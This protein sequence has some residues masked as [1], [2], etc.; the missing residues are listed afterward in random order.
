MASMNLK[1]TSEHLDGRAHLIALEGEADLYTAPEL[2]RELQDVIDQGADSVIVDLTET[3]FIDST[4]LGVLIGGV[5][6]LRPKGGSVSLICTDPNIRK[7]FEITL[8]DRVFPIYETRSEAMQQLDR[9]S[10]PS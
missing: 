3:T 4:T 6:R 8:L 9:A 2:K 1:V 7:I 5:K 10:E